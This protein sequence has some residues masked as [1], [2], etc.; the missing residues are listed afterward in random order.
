MEYRILGDNDCPIA[1]F[2]MNRGETLKL[3]RGAMAYMSGVEIQG[4]LNSKGGLLGAIGR[5]LAAGESMFITHAVAVEDHAVLG[6]APPIPGQI[7]RLSVGARQYRL[8]T[9]AFLACASTV[10]YDIKSQK[11][12]HALFGGTGGLFVMETTGQGDIL[13]NAFGSLVELEV[14]PDRPLTV[15]NQHVVAWD[16]D[17]SYSIEIASGMFGFTTGEGLVN[18]FQGSG[19]ILIQTR[20]VQSLAGAVEPFIATGN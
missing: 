13:I 3:E 17:L 12:S 1:E 6:I 10:N 9:G 8:N 19:R 14:T 2:H 16:R 15:D 11:L 20:N 7:S 4:K 18:K 5:S